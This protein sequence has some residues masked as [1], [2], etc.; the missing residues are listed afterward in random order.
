MTQ[1]KNQ[2]QIVKLI[3]EICAEDGYEY[4]AYSDDWAIMISK[5]DIDM[6][7]YGYKF[8]N[9]SGSVEKI[10]NDK[11]LVS[12][13]LGEYNIPRVVHHFFIKN[14][15]LNILGINESWDKVESIFN[16]SHCDVVIKPNDGTCG[17]GVKRINDYEVLKES[18]TKLFEH[19]YT[20]AIA[21]YEDILNEY[22]VILLDMQPMLIFRKIRPFVF[23]NGV[24]NLMKLVVN[25]YGEDFTGFDK[26]IDYT[27]VP[28]AN[29]K[30]NLLWKHNLCGGASPEVV[31]DEIIKARLM[32]VATA[33]AKVLKAHFVSVDIVDTMEGLKVL[34][35]NSGVCME[36]F[37]L[38]SNSNYKKAKEI[39]RK[40][41]ESYFTKKRL[42]KQ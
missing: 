26:N 35:I 13:I 6:Y 12:D 15:T 1:E 23:G 4:R 22:R 36:N 21:P 17:V 25:K 8:P 32:E 7:V 33:T 2:R 3:K 41:I 34:E 19:N 11:A 20:I 39:Y 27:I 28:K 14:T 37:S 18:V 29:E 10:C 38:S 5:D 9:N 31:V 24:D 42:Q 30:I 16:D 40:A